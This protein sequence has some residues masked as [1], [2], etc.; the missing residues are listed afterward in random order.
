MGNVPTLIATGL[1]TPSSV[2][3]DPSGKIYVANEYGGTTGNGSITIYAAGS[4]GQVLPVATI[5]GV[6]T[7]LTEP[8]GIALD[9]A[10]NIYVSNLFGGPSL[11]GSITEYAAGSNGDAAPIAI[12]TSTTF[13]ISEPQGIALDPAD[14]IYVANTSAVAS[15]CFRQEATA[16]RLRARVSPD[17]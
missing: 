10:G 8:V 11:N 12:I 16:T 3:K 2:V 14:S 7:G 13:A 4:T 1:G 9:S 17:H 6:N 5:S 15:R